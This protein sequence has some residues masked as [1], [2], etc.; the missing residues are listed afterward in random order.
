MV[1]TTPVSP[2]DD[3]FMVLLSNAD[4]VIF[5]A[6]VAGGQIRVNARGGDRYFRYL[7]ERETPLLQNEGFL[8]V[9]VRRR[10]DAGEHGYGFR[11]QAVGDF[12]RATLSEMT[13]QVYFGDDVAYLTANWKKRPGRWV[14]YP[15]HMK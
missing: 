10:R 7:A 9:R 14:L 13:T 2:L 8:V 12:T 5:R 11:F 4:G 3:R 1:P 15:R 6:E